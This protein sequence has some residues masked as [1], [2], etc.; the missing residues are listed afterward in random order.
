MAQ[1][2]I[3]FGWKIEDSILFSCFVR[4][5]NHFVR[6]ATIS[7]VDRSLLNFTLTYRGLPRTGVYRGLASVLLLDLAPF[8]PR[9]TVI[10]HL[11]L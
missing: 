3:D 4:G 2:W 9:L 10:L 7:R 5:A 6:S 1:W 8:V 11:T